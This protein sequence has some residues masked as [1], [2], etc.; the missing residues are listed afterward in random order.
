MHSRSLN[1]TREESPPIRSLQS[2]QRLI[3]TLGERRSSR[4]SAA[5]R[6]ASRGDAPSVTYSNR[7]RAPRQHR[8]LLA[9]HGPQRRQL[10]PARRGVGGSEDSQRQPEPQ[11]AGP[12]T[13]ESRRRW[14]SNQE[15]QHHASYGDY[16][17]RSTYADH[18]SYQQ[19][20]PN[21]NGTG[22]SV[23]SDP[24]SSFNPSLQVTPAT[25]RL[26]FVN[27]TGRFGIPPDH[28]HS[29]ASMPFGSVEFPSAL[30]TDHQ[31]NLVMMGP[32]RRPQHF[33]AKFEFNCL[34]NYITRSAADRLECQVQVLPPL[35][36]PGG[37]IDASIMPTDE[38]VSNVVICSSLLGTGMVAEVLF[39]MPDDCYPGISVILGQSFFL[40]AMRQH[41]PLTQLP[42]APLH[43]P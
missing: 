3:R 42:T 28:Q 16:A 5:R 34:V 13:D 30:P 10:Q 1:P 15:S 19:P 21:M 41:S 33:A 2:D 32:N 9:R 39:I 6:R 20:R 36:I 43:P 26:S 23:R 31:N 35:Q 14:R 7:S 4:T 40:G 37:M 22:P 12:L 24:S 17:T 29:I 18:G 38:Y 11:P 27:Q 25:P 8:G